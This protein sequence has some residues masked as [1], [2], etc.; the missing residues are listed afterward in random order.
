MKTTLIIAAL[1]ISGAA[2]AQS[3]GPGNANLSYDYLELR[4][5]DVDTNGGDGFRFNGSYDFGNNWLIVG[6]LTSLDFNNNIDA[7]IFE[8]GAGYVWNY[9]QDFDLVSTLRYARAD[10]DNSVVSADDDGLAFSAGIRG[11]LTPDFEIRGNVHHVTIGDSDSYLELAGDYYFA[12]QFSAG[13]SLEFAGDSDVV[14]I[15]GRW[16][17]K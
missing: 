4:F 11:R 15:G 7:S 13:I 17:F 16:F 5:V 9:S 10:V 1:L 2:F 6:G 8:I 12:P 14:S 3:S